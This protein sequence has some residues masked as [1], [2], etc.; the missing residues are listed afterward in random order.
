MRHV[1]IFLMAAALGALQAQEMKEG[2]T[3]EKARK[4]YQEALD[5]LK[6]RNTPAALENFKKANKQDGGHCQP[7]IKK[8]ITYALELRDWKSAEAAAA[9]VVADAQGDRNIA[10]AHLNTRPVLELIGIL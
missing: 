7:C 9:D 8:I 3:D 5:Y 10:V 4:T 6:Q 2:P 1:L